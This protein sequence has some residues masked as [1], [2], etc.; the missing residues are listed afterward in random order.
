[1]IPAARAVSS[2]RRSV[3][4]AG[5]SCE[6][7]IRLNVRSVSGLVCEKN[8]L[9]HQ[10]FIKI[11]IGYERPP[12]LGVDF[13]FVVPDAGGDINHW[14]FLLVIRHLCQSSRGSDTVKGAV[15]QDES[16]PDKCGITGA[17]LWTARLTGW[18]A[19]I[20]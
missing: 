11:R 16:R 4:P 6:G 8:G 1:M 10:E 5:Y 19:S 18:S 15:S 12:R 13:P 9:A 3:W 14:V 20:R 17:A 7:L 2:L